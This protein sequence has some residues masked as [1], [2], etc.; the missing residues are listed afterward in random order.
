MRALDM[1][2]LRISNR[3]AVKEGMHMQLPQTA[4]NSGCTPVVGMYESPLQLEQVYK[5]GH[6]TPNGQ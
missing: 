5:L 1:Q 4:T 3:R 6:T 2:T